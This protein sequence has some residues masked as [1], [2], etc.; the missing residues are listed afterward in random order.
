MSTCN[1]VIYKTKNQVNHDGKHA[2][3]KSPS[4]KNKEFGD[5]PGKVG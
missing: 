3:C 1:M 4:Y 5:F 2:K